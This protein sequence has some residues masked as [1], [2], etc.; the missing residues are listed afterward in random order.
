MFQRKYTK[1]TLNIKLKSYKTAKRVG[2]LFVYRMDVLLLDPE[3]AA[4]RSVAARLED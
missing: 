2:S 1:C 3:A 4:R